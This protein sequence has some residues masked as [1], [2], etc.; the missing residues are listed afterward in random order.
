MVKMAS[1]SFPTAKAAAALAMTVLAAVGCD[2][3]SAQQTGQ[4][5]PPEVNVV[6]VQPRDIAATFEQVG[7]TAGVR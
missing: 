3:P 1:N 4:M 2:K 7:Q 5:P 6:T